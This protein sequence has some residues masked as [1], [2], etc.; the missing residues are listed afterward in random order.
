LATPCLRCWRQLR[1]CTGRPKPTSSVDDA[2]A[3]GA[4][5]AYGAASYRSML[6]RPEQFGIATA[7]EVGVDTLA[8]RLRADVVAT[9]LPGILNPVVGARAQTQGR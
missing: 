2:R 4:G 3:D 9:H 6:P 7:D 5:Y 1:H 8:D